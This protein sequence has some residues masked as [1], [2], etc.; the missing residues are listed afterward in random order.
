M[1]AS[2]KQPNAPKGFSSN[3]IKKGEMAY[4][5]LP[6]VAWQRLLETGLDNL[7]TPPALTYFS[8]GPTY[9]L[10]QLMCCTENQ[11][12]ITLSALFHGHFHVLRWVQ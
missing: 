6:N 2:P 4:I 7:W 11:P 9:T 1:D 8:A 12:D 5:A 3:A 10:R